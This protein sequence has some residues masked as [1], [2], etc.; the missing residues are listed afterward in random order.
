MR[1]RRWTPRY[2]PAMTNEG[3]TDRRGG[4]WDWPVGVMIGG[5]LLFL[6]AGANGATG[7]ALLGLLLA[8]FGLVTFLARRGTFSSR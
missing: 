5:V 8:G 1:S 7:G 6:F 4:F 3:E 2:R